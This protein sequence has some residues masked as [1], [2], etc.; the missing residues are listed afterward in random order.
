MTVLEDLN[1]G[2]FGHGALNALCELNRTV[3]EAVVAH[4]ATHKT[5]NDIRRCGLRPG[6][7]P[8][9]GCNE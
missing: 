3:L 4:E 8:A 9:V 1:V 5:D 2:V 7:D 6:D